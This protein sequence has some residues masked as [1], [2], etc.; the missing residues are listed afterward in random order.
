M[1]PRNLNGLW[2]WRNVPA[3]EAHLA[4]LAAGIVIHLVVPVSLLDAQWIGRALGLALLVGGISLTVWAV[5]TVAE[6]D[7]AKPDRLV[8]GG[9][10]IWSRNPMYVAW[11]AIYLGITLLSNLAWPLLFFPGVLL[12]NHVQ[13]LHEERNLAREFGTEYRDYRSKTRRYL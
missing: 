8:V 2:R 4:G 10:Y 11:D 1:M 5:K 12:W 13:V 3:S 9:P 6:V 7:A